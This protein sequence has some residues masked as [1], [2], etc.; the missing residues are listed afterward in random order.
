MCHRYGLDQ[1]TIEAVELPDRS[2]EFGT[3][4][5]RARRITYT[6]KDP[7]RQE[8][9]QYL[10]LLLNRKKELEEEHFNRFACH[11]SYGDT[12][13]PNSTTEPKLHTGTQQKMD[14][15]TL[16]NPE[17]AV[18][19]ETAPKQLGLHCII[20]EDCTKIT[21][22]GI[23]NISTHSAECHTKTEKFGDANSLYSSQSIS[24][25]S[26]SDPIPLEE[27]PKAPL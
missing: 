3:Y 21:I 22:K 5:N 25:P 17:M 6:T 20:S 27:K 19:E 15:L 1:E 24:V 14:I 7:V 13:T 10:K 18:K 11:Y 9:L 26:N 2:T 23:Q 12:D 4:N 8:K 16:M